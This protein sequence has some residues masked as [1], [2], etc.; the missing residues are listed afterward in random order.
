MIQVQGPVTFRAVLPSALIILLLG[1]ILSTISAP[2]EWLG[3]YGWL[4]AP[5]GVAMGLLIYLLAYLLFCSPTMKTRSMHS[6]LVTLHQLFRNFTWVQIFVVSALAG[7]GE[8]LLIR[9]V[10]QTFLVGSLGSFLGI[11]GASLIFGLLHFMTKTYVVFTLALGLLFG[12]IFHYS[13]SMVVVM[14]GHAV[15]DVIAFSMIVKFPH[16]LGI[17]PVD[18]TVMKIQE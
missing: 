5:I 3:R 1:V 12:I 9:G 10:L 13:N 17:K 14:V 6:L 8:E 11:I 4:A 7:I 16:L 15:Y 18:I 2:W